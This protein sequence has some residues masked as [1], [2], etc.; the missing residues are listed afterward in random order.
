MIA[1][2]Q[3]TSADGHATNGYTV[4][5]SGDGAETIRDLFGDTTLPL[6]ITH[7]AP[8]HRAIEMV[9]RMPLLI[10]AEIRTAE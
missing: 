5:I 6:P 4:T 1:T 2:I 10:G 7:A 3:K 9:R 8:M